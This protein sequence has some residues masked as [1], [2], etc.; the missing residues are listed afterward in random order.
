LSSSVSAVSNSSPPRPDGLHQHAV[1]G[2]DCDVVDMPGVGQMC[3]RRFFL[4]HDTRITG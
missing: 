2:L 4:R 3:P 1:A